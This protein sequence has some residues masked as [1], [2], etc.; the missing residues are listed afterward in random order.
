[1]FIHSSIR[2]VCALIVCVCVVGCGPGNPHKRMAVSGSVKF[3]GVALDQG[4]I[5]FEPPAGST[6]HVNASAVI[7]N[8]KYELPVAGGLAP[9]S[10]KVSISS[11]A[12]AAPLSNDPVKAMED[13]SKPPPPERIPAKYNAATELQIEVKQQETPNKFDFDLKS[14]S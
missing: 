12:A 10:Y 7:T 4:L 14:A 11:H 13:A 1:M 8:G 9:G 3:D 6:A 2:T 5:Q